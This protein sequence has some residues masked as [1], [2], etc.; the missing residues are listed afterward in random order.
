VETKKWYRFGSPTLP[1]GHGLI[2]VP[3]DGG[4]NYMYDPVWGDGPVANVYPAVPGNPEQKSGAQNAAF[5]Q[6][7]YK[8]NV[9][10]HRGSPFHKYGTSDPPVQTTLSANVS[11]SADFLPAVSTR[12]FDADGYI[13]IDDERISYDGR[14]KNLTTLNGDHTA[15]ATTLMST[16]APASPP[17]A[18]RSSARRRSP[19]QAT[20]STRPLSTAITT[21]QQRRS[22]STRPRTFQP[23]ARSSSAPRRSPTPARPTR[24]SPAA[25]AEPTA[26]QPRHTTTVPMWPWPR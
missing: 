21:P 5:R 3:G 26:R 11:D 10:Y 17:A 1:D 2:F 13:A 22:P 6:N 25:P 19:T 14:N 23:P 15:A 12:S 7:W 18:P 9:A 20:T 8:D 16:A 24:P 4:N